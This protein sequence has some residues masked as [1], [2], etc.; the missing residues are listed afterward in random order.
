MS[1]G[2][3]NTALSVFSKSISFLIFAISPV[4]PIAQATGSRTAKV[5]CMFTELRVSAMYFTK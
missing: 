2:N 4:V 3:V 1:L 5:A